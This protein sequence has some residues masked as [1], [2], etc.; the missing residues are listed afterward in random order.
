[1]N[2][3]IGGPLGR[4]LADSTDLGPAQAGTVQLTAALK[5]STRPQ[6]LIE[7]AQ[8]HRLSVRWRS[9]D[10]WA[11][12]QGAPVDVGT[13]FGVAV[14]DYRSPDGQVF[15][16]SAVQPAIPDPVRA[17]VT[18]LGRILSYNPLRPN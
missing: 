18:E 3:P 6:A 9:G 11:Y 8:G 13:A 1:M 14:H 7:W 16:A 5:N 2:E 10:D 12:V 4:L 15:Y 17:E